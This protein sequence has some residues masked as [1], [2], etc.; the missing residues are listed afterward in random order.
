MYIVLGF[1][2]WIA[3]IYPFYIG[4]EKLNFR[5]SLFVTYKYAREYVGGDAY[6]YII[7]S[8]Q[9]TS[10]FIIGG[11]LILSGFM[12]FILYYLHKNRIIEKDTLKNEVK[13]DKE[14]ENIQQ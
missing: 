7:N 2:S 13:S 14:Q 6:N 3:S 4:W 11:I 9:S 5:V 12:F 1:L 10:Y 8:T